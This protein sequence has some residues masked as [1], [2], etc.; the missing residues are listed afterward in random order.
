[1]RFT[2]YFLGRIS[3]GTPAIATIAVVKKKIKTE[4]FEM[5]VLIIFLLNN[6]IF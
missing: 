1:M 2:E 6:Y 4:M 5:K 3:K